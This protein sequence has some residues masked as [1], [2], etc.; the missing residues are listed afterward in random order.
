MARW[1]DRWRSVPTDARIMPKAML[2]RSGGQGRKPVVHSGRL[3]S[4]PAKAI[5]PQARASPAA[6]R[7]IPRRA[8]RVRPARVDK[9]RVGEA[10][11]DGAKRWVRTKPIY[12]PVTS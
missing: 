3:A 7:L 11:I 5:A 2:G 8:G 10:G 1:S 9:R 12:R 4:Q 6:T